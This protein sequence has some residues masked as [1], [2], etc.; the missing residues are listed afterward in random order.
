[1]TQPARRDY[2]V[3]PGRHRAH[4]A[5]RLASGFI[6]ADFEIEQDFSGKRPE[7]KH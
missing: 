3:M 2:R 1:M 6:G 7:E 5:E 4:A